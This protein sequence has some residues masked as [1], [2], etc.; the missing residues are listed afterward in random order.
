MKD[1]RATGPSGVSAAMFKTM[2][3][4]G[5]KEVTAALQQIAR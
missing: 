5:V 4:V 2:E 3:G 1:K